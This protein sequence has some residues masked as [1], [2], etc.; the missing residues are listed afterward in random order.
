MDVQQG[1]EKFG[2]GF[3]VPHALTCRVHV[4]Y[5]SFTRVF[6]GF[7]QVSGKKGV[8]FTGGMVGF[9]GYKLRVLHGRILGFGLGRFGG[10]RTWGAGFQ[11]CGF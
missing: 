7:R 3:L 2:S 4:M 5:K 11:G 9:L 1:F 10:A 6:C 8:G